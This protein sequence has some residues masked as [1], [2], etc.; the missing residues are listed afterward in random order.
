MCFDWHREPNF[1]AIVLVWY[2]KEI[3]DWFELSLARGAALLHNV[4]VKTFA[5]DWPRLALPLLGV[6]AAEDCSK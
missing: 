1:G 4:V 3:A 5:F 2:F 6:V